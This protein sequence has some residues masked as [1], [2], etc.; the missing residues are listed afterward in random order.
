M[1]DLEKRL[2]KELQQNIRVKIIDSASWSIA[3]HSIE[4][5]FKPVKRTKMDVLMKMMLLTFQKAKITKPNELSDLLLVEQLFIEDLLNIMGRTGLIE[6]RESVYTLTDRGLRQLKNGIFEEDQET[7]TQTLLYSPTHEDFLQGEIKPALDGE[8]ELGIYRYA[9]EESVK[10][11]FE[12]LQ[13][14]DALRTSGVE[15]EEGDIQIV[16]SEI[17]STSELYIDDV[18][19]LEFIL[20]NKEEDLLYARVWNTF[21]GQWDETLE[22]E[23]NEKERV[24]WKEKYL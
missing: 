3:V 4:V 23:L 17:V 22:N 12:D 11:K 1:R 8:E 13:V 15:A 7:K 24:S 5:E 2:K 10:I 19:C 6:K 9:K 21:L 18:P 20:H 14:I 16:V